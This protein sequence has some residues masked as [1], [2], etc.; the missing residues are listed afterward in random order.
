M[1]IRFNDLPQPVRE[2]FVQISAAP[3]LDPRVI[4][5]SKS[6]GGVWFYY[7]GGVLALPSQILRP[8]SYE[9]A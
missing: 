6:F 4:V 2:R 7:V 9:A 8:L 3:G 1:A 5:H